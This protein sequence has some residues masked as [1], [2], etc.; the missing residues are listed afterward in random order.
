MAGD[1]DEMFV[2][3]S[4]NVTA[5]VNNYLYKI[6][7]RI[8]AAHKYPTQFECR[9]SSFLSYLVNPGLIKWIKVVFTAG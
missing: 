8:V 1:G 7:C 9:S 2:T 4:F 3:R 6:T 5:F